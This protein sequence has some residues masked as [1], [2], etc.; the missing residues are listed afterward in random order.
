[1]NMAEI[2][3]GRLS[4][5]AQRGASFNGAREL[6][7]AVMDFMDAHSSIPKPCVWKK[8]KVRGSQLR[9]TTKNLRD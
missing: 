5:K 3:F 7:E 6:A 4:E 1:M 2:W 8:R 9:N